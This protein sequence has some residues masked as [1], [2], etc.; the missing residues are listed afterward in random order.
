LQKIYSITITDTNRLI[1]FIKIIAA[2]SHEPHNAVCN[3]KAAA[4][5]CN[6]MAFK[7]VNERQTRLKGI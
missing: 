1:I 3:V 6:Q 7:N 2:Q 4:T 5:Y